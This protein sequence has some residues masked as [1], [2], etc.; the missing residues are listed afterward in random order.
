MKNK[1]RHTKLGKIKIQYKQIDKKAYTTQK[2]GLK[3]SVT[4]NDKTATGVW[5]PTSEYIS[6]ADVND[7]RGP[8]GRRFNIF[9]S[10]GGKRHYP[11]YT[12]LPEKAKQ[13]KNL[14][15]TGPYLETKYLKKV[16][17][18]KITKALDGKL[19]TATLSDNFLKYFN[20]KS[21][22]DN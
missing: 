12:G 13:P 1:T 19:K 21:V 20:L 7:L 16:F 8:D 3:F 5:V 14:Q 17:I 10:G 15:F 4:I 22:E 9:S 18:D 11:I 6:D 2:S